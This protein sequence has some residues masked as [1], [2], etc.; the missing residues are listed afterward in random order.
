MFELRKIEKSFPGVRALKGVDLRVERGEIVGL[1]G[2][3]GAGKSTLMKIMYGAYRHDAGE[4]F[5]N[6]KAVAFDNPRQ[7][8]E[9]GVGMVFQE[10]SLIGN[11]TVMENIFLGFEKQFVRFGVIDWKKM[12]KAAEYQLAKVRLKID[13]A[14]VTSRLSFAQR[15]LVELAKVL[16]LEERTSGELVILLDEPTSVLDKEEVALL[17]QLVRDLRGRAG[18]VFVSHRLDEVIE[19]SD[20]IYVL[21]DGEVA[22]VVDAD[23][24]IVEDI[25]RKMVGRNI[26]K[27]YYREDSQKPYDPERILLELDGIGRAGKYRDISLRL[28]AGEVM[29]LVGVEGAGREAILRSV[30]GLLRPHTGSITVKG[31]KFHSNSAAVGVHRG[32]GYVPR[33]RKIEGIIGGLSIYEN[34]TLS[35]MPKYSRGGVLR[36]AG[37]RE[38]AREWIRKLSIKAASEMV[39]CGNLSGGNQQ[40]VVLAK[41]RSGGSDIILLDHP[42]R[43]LDIGAKED[44]YTMVREMCEAGCGVVLIAD[45][46]EEAIGLAHTIAVIKDGEI[47]EWFQCRPGAKP[48]L[49]DLIHHMV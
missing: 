19:L 7:A 8:M 2:E 15:Q 26:S 23:A 16:T 24:A 20:R 10:Q 45:T 37:E 42:T 5:I 34:M 40:K 47:Q 22:D 14:T 41:W 17:F 6:G 38:Q 18:F 36:I 39:D 46:L 13:P 27:E 12:A 4:M 29:A 9:Q 1:V 21:K 31:E 32:I 44:V 35:Q 33:E 49:Y 30:F 28:H 11:L 25:Q 3:N 43:G 48:S